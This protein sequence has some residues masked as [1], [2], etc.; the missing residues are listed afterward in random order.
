MAPLPHPHSS[1]LLVGVA[2]AAA[3]LGVACGQPAA[4]V[5]QVAALEAEHQSLLIPSSDTDPASQ[6]HWTPPVL[7]SD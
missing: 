5:T 2:A 4:V 6:H 3:I 7:D 1:R